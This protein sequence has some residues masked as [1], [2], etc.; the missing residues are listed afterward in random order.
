MLKY[1]NR[2]IKAKIHLVSK[3]CPSKPVEEKERAKRRKR[4]TKRKK[5][6]EEKSKIRYV[7]VLESSVL[8]S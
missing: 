5:K 3:V 6:E 2:K 8:D 1:N 4:R 7:V